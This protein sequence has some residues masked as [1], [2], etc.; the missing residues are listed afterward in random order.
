MDLWL[1]SPLY[2]GPGR[3]DPGA[4]VVAGV[5]EARVPDHQAVVPGHAHP[6]VLDTSEPGEQRIRKVD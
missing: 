6:A 4:E 3:V 2:G 5:L 1:C